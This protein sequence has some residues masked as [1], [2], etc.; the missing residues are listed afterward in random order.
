M[1]WKTKQ[2]TPTLYFLGELTR[3]LAQVTSRPVE[4]EADRP[5]TH[6]LIQI[7][8][9]LSASHQNNQNIIGLSIVQVWGKSHQPLPSDPRDLDRRDKAVR[10]DPSGINLTRLHPLIDPNEV[11]YNGKMWAPIDP[12]TKE[13][14]KFLLRKEQE[15]VAAEKFLEAVPISEAI[16]KVLDL[17]GQILLLQ[18]QLETEIWE[19]DFLSAAKTK[20]KLEILLR[21]REEWEA[22]FGTDNFFLGMVLTDQG[23]PSNPAPEPHPRQ[24]HISDMRYALASLKKRPKTPKARTPKA[25]YHSPS[26]PSTPKIQPQTP[27]SEELK[28]PKTNSNDDLDA[29]LM[30]LADEYNAAGPSESWRS[31]ELLNRV[32]SIGVS[33]IF[34]TKVWAMLGESNWRLR[35]I[36]AQA[37]LAYLESDLPSRKNAPSVALFKAVCEFADVLLDDKVIKLFVIGLKI[38]R[39][40]LSPKVCS[41]EIDTETFQKCTCSLAPKLLKKCSELNHRTRAVSLEALLEFFVHP[42]TPRSLVVSALVSE[43]PSEKW[44]A[45]LGVYQVEK[46]KERVVMAKL[47]AFRLLI[48]QEEAG[49]EHFW[50]I[51]DEL[52]LPS[53]KHPELKVRAKAADLCLLMSRVDFQATL[54]R[55][56]QFGEL[57]PHSMIDLMMRLFGEDQPQIVQA[58]AMQKNIDIGKHLAQDLEEAVEEEPASARKSNHDWRTLGESAQTFYPKSDRKTELS[59]FKY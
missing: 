18:V 37:V 17:G 44:E 24:L 28:P 50:P 36:A 47:E 27:K 26:P 39:I 22:K 52:V 25:S 15:S 5:A 35:E 29:I 58:F 10:L 42:L 55:V 4:V 8:A 45:T 23:P 32:E 48:E 11:R 54:D 30:R 3:D 31:L 12:V 16:E 6:V 9:A 41:A 34:G 2:G 57:N 7:R 40:G 13:L 33:E 51:F 21:Q 46:E 53:L 43:L 56:F 19:K 1:L 20:Q 38:L 59:R 14:F 49:T